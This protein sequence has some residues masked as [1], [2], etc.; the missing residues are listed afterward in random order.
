MTSSPSSSVADEIREGLSKS[1]KHLSPA[2]LYD[3][4][5]SELFDRITQLPEYY[6]ARKETQILE[7]EAEELLEGVEEIVELGSGYSRKTQVLLN[8]LEQAE[9]SRYVALDVSQSAIE[10]SAPRLIADHPTL[11]IE[12]YVANFEETLDI[13][14][15]R[16][17]RMV[18]L[19]GSTLGNFKRED[20]ISFL[21]R[22]KT[23]LEP[24]DSFLVGVDLVKDVEIL[25]AAYDDSAGLAAEFGLNLIKVLNRDFDGNLPIDAFRYRAFFDHDNSWIDM[26]IKA[27]R[28]VDARLEKLD[29]DMHFDKGEEMRTEVSKKFTRATFEADLNAA[30]LELDHWHTDDKAWFGLAQARV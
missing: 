20:R 27:T 21:H 18:V 14:E 9:G 8:A 28:A 23:M 1:P 22:V 2:F 12:G 4:H 19:L 24:E 15:H 11:D 13:V 5:G 30:G 10:A 16:G 3:D 6:L 17:R 26:R 7:R 29:F 25:E